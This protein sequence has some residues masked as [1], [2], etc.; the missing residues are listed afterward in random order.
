MA[1][2]LTE[3][4]YHIV[5]STKNREPIINPEIQ[6]KL[7]RYITGI[8]K[9]DDAKLLQSGG[10]EDHIHL[11]IKMKPTHT[12]SE[13]VQKIKGHSSKWIN[14]QKDVNNKFSWQ[15]GYGAFTVSESQLPMVIKYVKDQEKHHKEM[16]FKDELVIFLKRHHIEYDE[17]YLWG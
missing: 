8:I 2:T 13:L 16:S 9:K 11:V 15:E 1:S 17:K 4:I 5:F 12:L 10:I 7:Y 3:L 14:K 6:E